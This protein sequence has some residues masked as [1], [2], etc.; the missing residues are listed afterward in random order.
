MARML[1][2]SCP[3][4]VGESVAGRR[5]AVAGDARD[6]SSVQPLSNFGRR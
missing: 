2:L 5:A 6:E 3:A 4:K 1:R